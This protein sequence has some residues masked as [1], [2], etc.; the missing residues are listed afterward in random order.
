MM[1]WRSTFKESGYSQRQIQCAI[2]LPVR[3]TQPIEKPTLFA[4]LPY[5]QMAYFHISRMPAEDI[6]LLVGLPLRKF[7]S[8]LYPVKDD[9][10]LKT[11]HV[12]SILYDCG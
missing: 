11:A 10:G 7:S 4:F 1:N 3:T 9:V 2:I 6:I 12:C 8:S 5:V